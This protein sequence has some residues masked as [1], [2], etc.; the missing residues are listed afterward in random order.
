MPCGLTFRERIGTVHIDPAATPVK[1]ERRNSEG[2]RYDSDAIRKVFG[3]DS[4]EE[5]MEHTKGLGA[6]HSRGGEVYHRDRHSGEVSRVSEEQVD[7]V[8]LGG[9]T[10]QG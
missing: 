1:T 6:A 8:Y 3:E 7:Q 9:N 2:K 5:L 10:A 4:R